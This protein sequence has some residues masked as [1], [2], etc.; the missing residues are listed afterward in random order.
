MRHITW[1]HYAIKPF[2]FDGVIVIG[3]FQMEFEIFIGSVFESIIFA[4][5]FAAGFVG[6]L[7]KLEGWR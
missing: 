1:I 7:A 5:N 2:R 4:A 3:G 6:E